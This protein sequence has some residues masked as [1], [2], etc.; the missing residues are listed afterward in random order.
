MGG[1]VFDIFG[2]AA[3]GVVGVVSGAVV[4]EGD[5]V[6]V[7]DVESR[8]DGVAGGV[9]EGDACCFVDDVGDGGGEGDERG[10]DVDVGGVGAEEV[11]GVEGGV[12][13]VRAA[14]SDYDE[15]D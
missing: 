2:D 5:V 9:G 11:E 7:C 4:P 12:V 6:E 14:E 3:G 10:V 13:L 15:A 1:A 8:F